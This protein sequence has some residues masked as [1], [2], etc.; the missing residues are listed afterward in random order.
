MTVHI[1]DDISFDALI[2]ETELAI[3]EIGAKHCPPCRALEAI[4]RRAAA[5]H[6]EVRF[7]SVDVEEAPALALR[8]AVRA[9]PTVVLLSRGRPITTRVGLLHPHQLEELLADARRGSP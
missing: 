5:A 9:T 8:F 3:V 2:A 1:A 7:V 4:F 6:P